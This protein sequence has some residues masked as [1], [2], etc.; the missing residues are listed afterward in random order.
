MWGPKHRLLLVLE[1]LEDFKKSPVD[2]T[3]IER[4]CTL[5]EC[6]IVEVKGY[7]DED[8]SIDEEKKEAA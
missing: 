4:F 1:A 2:S 3:S 5:T 7:I 6:L 8:G